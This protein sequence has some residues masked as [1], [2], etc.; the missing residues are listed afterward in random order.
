MMKKVAIF[1]I[2]GTIFRSSALIEIVEILIEK[3]FFPASARARYQKEY[4]LWQDREG[5][6]EAYIAAVVKAFK[7]NIRGVHYSELMECAKI[8]QERYRNRVYR[9]TRDLVHDLKEKEYYL[10][11][12]TQSPKSVV[13]G[14]CKAW[15]FD[16]VYGRIYE[17]GPSDRFTGIMLDEHLIE[18]KSAIVRRAVEKEGLTLEDSFAVGDT[19]GDIPM[20]EMVEHPIC[21]NPNMRLY[22]HAKMCGWKVVVERK[23]V[24]YEL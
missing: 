8:M 14:F 21:F 20:L 5:D 13:D 9:Y 16:K 18:N 24:I 1:D 10:L 12:I 3:G 2:D 15:G 17:I 19:E 7:E 4:S 6:Y 11:A 22:R 23:D